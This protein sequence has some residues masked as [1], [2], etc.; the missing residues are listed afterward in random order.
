[1]SLRPSYR[2]RGELSSRSFNPAPNLD[3]KN[4]CFPR[5]DYGS[6]LRPN[7]SS[8]PVP[9]RS[10]N[11]PSKRNYADP[12]YLQ[13]LK[14]AHYDPSIEHARKSAPSV[15]DTAPAEF[16]EF[17]QQLPIQQKLYFAERQPYVP[18][19]NLTSV[20][21]VHLRLFYDSKNLPDRFWAPTKEAILPLESDGGLDLTPLKKL[22]NQNTCIPISPT[23]FK[24]VKRADPD[25]LSP[26]TVM[27]LREFFG[28]ITF[29]SAPFAFSKIALQKLIEMQVVV[30]R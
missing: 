4:Q 15:L 27:M 23:R 29:I 24:P 19:G 9:R 20:R 12:S 18:P 14:N 6:T 2:H 5:I 22:W 3:L 26:M 1:M 17:L 28:C 30:S 25:R 10:N 8:R 11:W 16:R 7:T 13:R 21:Y